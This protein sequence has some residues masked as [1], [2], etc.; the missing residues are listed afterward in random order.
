METESETTP[1][2]PRNEV[3]YNRLTGLGPNPAFLS[4]AGIR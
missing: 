2:S 3:L 4:S 1:L